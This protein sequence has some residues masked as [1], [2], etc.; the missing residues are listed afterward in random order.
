ME[1]A[2]SQFISAV[3]PAEYLNSISIY[4]EGDITLAFDKKINYQNTL[5]INW[6]RYLIHSNHEAISGFGKTVV[7]I[8]FFLIDIVTLPYF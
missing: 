6:Q 4:K 2:A 5:S 3:K 7:E 1:I 8:L